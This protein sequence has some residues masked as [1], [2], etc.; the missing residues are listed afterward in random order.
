M[1]TPGSVAEGNLFDAIIV[2]EAQAFEDHW[3]ISPPSAQRPTEW[4][5]CLSFD[6]NQRL[7]NEI[8]S[9]SMEQPPFFLTENCRNS[10]HIHAALTPY[11]HT[12]GDVECNGPEGRPVEMIPAPTPSAA[13]QELQRVLHRLVNEEQIPLNDS[14]VLTPSS[15]K[16]SH[17][18]P[19][20]ILGNFILTWDTA[21]DMHHAVRV[22][23]IY[24]FKRL[25]SAI[26][27][28]RNW[29]KPGADRRP[30]CHEFS[31]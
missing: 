27:I 8:G 6:D 18:K 10:Q 13:K 16:R 1:H 9:V 23:T 17:W 14:I 2:D 21:S 3:W 20:Q 15:E 4:L 28:L 11:E 31:R 22:S 19:D 12:T 7:Y 24:R 5:L 29:N 30:F 25:R 26:V